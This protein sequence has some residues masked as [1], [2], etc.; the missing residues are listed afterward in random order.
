M[1]NIADLV[2]QAPDPNAKK[3]SS[4]WS[5]CFCFPTASA[6]EPPPP[7]ASQLPTSDISLQLSKKF[8]LPPLDKPGQKCLVLDLDETLVHSSFQKIDDSDFE[9]EILLE[10]QRHKVY[11]RKRPGVDHFLTEVGK[12]FEVVVFTASLSKYADPLLDVLDPNQVVKHRL[13]REDCV[14]HGSNY[15]KDLTCLGRVLEHTIIVD[16]SPYSYQ[17]QKDNAIPIKTWIDE[18]SDRQLTHLL[19][20]LDDLAECDDIVELITGLRG[21]WRFLND[22]SYQPQFATK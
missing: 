15:V 14:Q 18:P 5:C 13:F 10:G 21:D 8:L 2:T 17:F 20:F 9:I 7:T 3:A 16:N 19:P 6:A 12:K 4:P 1:S 11:V 22:N